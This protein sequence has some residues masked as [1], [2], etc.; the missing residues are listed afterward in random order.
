MGFVRIAD[1]SIGE[2]L[3]TGTWVLYPSM[4]IPLNSNLGP[5]RVE[6]LKASLGTT[7]VCAAGCAGGMGH[8]AGRRVAA[9]G[10]SLF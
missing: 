2:R 7:L 6:I 1:R 3:P 5:G 10:R 4:V 8:I 9:L